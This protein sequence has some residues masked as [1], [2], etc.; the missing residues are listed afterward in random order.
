MKNVLANRQ[1][2]G[3]RIA[4]RISN[5]AAKHLFVIKSRTIRNTFI[6]AIGFGALAVIVLPALLSFVLSP[7]GKAH[8]EATPDTCF[9]YTTSGSSAT[10]TGY[11]ND[12][13]LP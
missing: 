10:I 11:S 5:H 4:Q 3:E 8:A 13:S 1:H 7:S 9:T 6:G 2:A 12:A